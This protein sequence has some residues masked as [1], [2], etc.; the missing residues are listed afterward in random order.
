MTKTKT[1]IIKACLNTGK[2]SISVTLPFALYALISIP[3]LGLD[4]QT[5]LASKKQ[6]LFSCHGSPALRACLF[7]ARYTDLMGDLC[8]T[9]W[10]DTVSAGLKAKTTAS[11]L[12]ATSAHPSTCSAPSALRSCS[13]ASWHQ[14]HLLSHYLHGFMNFM[15]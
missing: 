1:V 2:K 3:L 5:L 9:I 10:A 15:V 14:I 8:P 12:T 11:A 4:L 6:H 13:I 7:K